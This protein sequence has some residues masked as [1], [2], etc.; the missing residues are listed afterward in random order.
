MTDP[1]PQPAPGDDPRLAVKTKWYWLVI[2]GIVMLVGGFLCLMR[3]FAASI[4]VTAFAAIAFAIVG[5]MMIV[6]AVRDDAESTGGRLL[7]G[8]GGAVF[9][10]F[11]LSLVA[12]P[13]AGLISLTFLAALLFITTGALQAGVAWRLRPQ[14]PWGWMMVSGVISILLGL[15][16]IATLPASSIAILGILLGIDLLSSGVAYVML[17]LFVRRAA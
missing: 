1:Q 5:V 7:T 2:M 13:L 4:T 3:P 17:G 11:A 15:Y 16:I 14:K 8:L 6:D 9:L 10:F 12:N